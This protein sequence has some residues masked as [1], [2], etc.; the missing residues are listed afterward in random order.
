M[1]CVYTNIE[2]I[3]RG[4]THPSMIIVGGICGMLAGL[5]N[6]ITPAMKMYKQCILSA[7]II[8]V[9]EYISGWI[10]NIKLGLNIWDYTNLKFNLNENTV[11]RII[12]DMIIVDTS[13]NDKTSYSLISNAKEY[14]NIADIN[15]ILETRKPENEL[16]DLIIAVYKS[17][18]T[19]ET[20]KNKESEGVSTLTYID[21][22]RV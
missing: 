11:Y 10:L 4:Y 6:D 19:A 22:K 14:L 13:L 15:E 17:Y 1:G 16:E 20:D 12:N 8:T 7:V 18:L 9:V 5:I 2:M 21:L 3:F